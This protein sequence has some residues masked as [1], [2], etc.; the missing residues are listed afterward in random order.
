MLGFVNAN[1]RS[2]RFNNCFIEFKKATANLI[3][4]LV[5]KETARL[6]VKA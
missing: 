4:N 3:V 5:K 1:A 6:Y 2:N